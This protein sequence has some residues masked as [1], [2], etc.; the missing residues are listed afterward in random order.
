M[1]PYLA[2][3]DIERRMNYGTHQQ[4][5]IKWYLDK[6]GNSTVPSVPS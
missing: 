3:D 2:A 6:D 5:V 4:I 1:R